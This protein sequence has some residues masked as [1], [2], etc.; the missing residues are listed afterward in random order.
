MVKLGRSL[1]PYNAAHARAMPLRRGFAFGG[2]AWLWVGK[3]TAHRVRSATGGQ[4]SE[5]A[6]RWVAKLAP[7]T[8][9]AGGGQCPHGVLIVKA[10]Q[11]RPNA[12]GASE[13]LGCIGVEE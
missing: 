3:T 6:H 1:A 10:P 12:L 4:G 9:T 8:R 7:M 11:V 5:T 2:L 13:P